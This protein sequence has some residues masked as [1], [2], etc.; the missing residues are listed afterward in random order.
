MLKIRYIVFTLTL[1]TVLLGACSDYDICL[2]SANNL[3]VSPNV[4]E[5]E[6]GVKKV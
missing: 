1:L 4:C 3:G 6:N 5:T 2:R